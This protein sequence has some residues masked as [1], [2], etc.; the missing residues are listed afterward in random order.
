MKD[1][2]LGCVYHSLRTT[3]EAISLHK[4][5]TLYSEQGRNEEAA[6]FYKMK[7]KSMESKDR[8]IPKM[9]QALLF[10]GKYYH[11]TNR[12]EAAEVYC[13]SLLKHSHLESKE[14]KTA[15]CLLA[16]IQSTQSHLPP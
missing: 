16:E 13:T 8:D 10:L 6:L 4:L 2:F 5:A 9:L 14:G 11:S 1:I 7:L 15:N 3:G 12:F